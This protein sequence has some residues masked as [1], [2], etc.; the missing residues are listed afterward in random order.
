MHRFARSIT[1]LAAA[2][3]TL[4]IAAG[5]TA[6][7]YPSK[8]IRIVLPFPP[9]AANDMRARIVA[10]KLS[11]SLGQPVMVEN[12]AGADG[13][14][15]TEMVAKAA[16]DGHTLLLTVHGT[17][18]AN[19]VLFKKIRYDPVNDFAH[20]TQLMLDTTTILTVNPSL[21]VTSVKELIALAKAKPGQL[22]YSTASSSFYL[23]NE[24]FKLRTGIDM[25]YVPYKGAAPSIMALISGDTQVTFS[26]NLKPAS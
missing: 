12:K 1:L 5:V 16:P 9:G 24:M 13:A 19:P 22:N 3:L 25:V 14:I 7:D 17:V 20:I 2:A 10:D 18:V 6:A 21:P 26:D 23:I 11:Q 8:P 4:G 15:G